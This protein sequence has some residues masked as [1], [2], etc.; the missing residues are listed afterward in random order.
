MVVEDILIWEKETDLFI[1]LI[2][3]MLS[4][5]F[6]LLLQNIQSIDTKYDSQHIVSMYCNQTAYILYKWCLGISVS[7]LLFYLCSPYII[8]CNVC[9]VLRMLLL[10]SVLLLLIATVF[11][12]W[13]VLKFLRTDR[14]VNIFANKKGKTKDIDV[15]AW[16]DLMV[17]L[18]GRGKDKL[19][20]KA[21]EYISYHVQ[22]TRKNQKKDIEYTAEINKSIVKINDELCKSKE[23]Y[24]SIFNSIGVLTVYAGEGDWKSNSVITRNNIWRCL[25]A[26]IKYQRDDFIYSHW[27]MAH[28]RYAF[29]GYPHKANDGYNEKYEHDFKLF[30][31]ALGA[32]L[33]YSK[34]YKLLRKCLYQSYATPPQYFLTPNSFDEIMM[35]Y[36]EISQDKYITQ[37][38]IEKNYQFLD[39]EDVFN[40]LVRNCIKDYLCMLM[41]R[42]ETIVPT[43]IYE[44]PWQE[45]DE[46][47]KTTV[48]ISNT[49]RI[50][51]EIKKRLSAEIINR[52]RKI[53]RWRENGDKQSMPNA[54]DTF[55]EDFSNK[56]VKELERA[57]NAI[58]ADS[59]ILVN[60]KNKV[61][62]RIENSVQKFGCFIDSENKFPT[63]SLNP[64]VTMPKGVHL[65]NCSLYDIYPTE[66]F[67]IDIEYDISD[68]AESIALCITSELKRCMTQFIMSRGYAKFNVF[69]KEA[70]EALQ[71]IHVNENTL[72]LFY[73]GCD[74]VFR[75]DINID[76]YGIGNYKGTDVIKMNGVIGYY[77]YIVIIDKREMPKLDFI[78]PSEALKEKHGLEL[79][80]EE[81]K[82]YWG[83]K[84]LKNNESLRKEIGARRGILDDELK[85]KSSLYIHL[86]ARLYLPKDCIKAIIV[87]NDDFSKQ[88]SDLDKIKPM[89]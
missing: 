9:D 54:L 50:L 61:K 72:L 3:T 28:Q 20:M 23:R 10:S 58:T 82:L 76:D 45:Y 85:K 84:E 83:Y 29:Y 63:D 56:L 35:W 37:F 70:E 49:I 53:L 24:F 25:L 41:V 19:A 1:A 30:Y 75:D 4:I 65:M 33:L 48:G 74:W 40:D 62:N 26:Q 38:S 14:L 5:C 39:N 79:L 86:Y 21:Y 66:Y 80:S 47:E 88:I 59:D 8:G 12:F 7:I 77:N 43:F 36:V 22:N 15:A 11:M 89:F 52:W 31:I 51:D 67:S 60:Y 18:I 13:D 32:H 73:D 57:K 6:P 16:T 69:I 87:L 34:R 17:Y 64:I 42:L 71:R 46:Y 78:A 2:S 27:C 68:F 55:I 44:N 81:T